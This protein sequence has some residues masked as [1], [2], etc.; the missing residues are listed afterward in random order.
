MSSSTCHTPSHAN[1]RSS[2]GPTFRRLESD[3][4]ALSAALASPEV[5]VCAIE[6]RGD[7][8]SSALFV[9]PVAPAGT[10]SFGSLVS[11]IEIVFSGE[12]PLVGINPDTRIVPGPSVPFFVRP[13]ADG[14]FAF[15]M[16]GPGT[17]RAFYIHVEPG[18]EMRSLGFRAEPL[19]SVILEA[20]ARTSK[21]DVLVLITN[22]TGAPSRVSLD[23]YGG[24]RLEEVIGAD[25]T[26]SMLYE[27]GAFGKVLTVG[28]D[29]EV[30]VINQSGGTEQVDIILEPD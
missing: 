26:A 28:L 30:T 25:D 19:E 5:A 16:S 8:V 7:S 9:G 1:G 24:P 29:P 18:A 17:G 21:G 22:L 4:E 3:S 14:E 15:T 27:F 11:P 12:S 2:Y 10:V 13:D 6:I 23:P 20:H